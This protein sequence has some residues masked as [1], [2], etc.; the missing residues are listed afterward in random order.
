MPDFF[1][2]KDFKDDWDEFVINAKLAEHYN[3]AAQISGALL[4]HRNPILDALLP[5]LLYINLMSLL[6]GALDL[7][8]GIK[9]LSIPKTYRN[10]LNGKIGFLMDQNVVKNGTAL[11]TL[12]RKR[13]EAAHEVEHVD[14]NFF[15]DAI[16]V[17]NEELK[18][19]GFVD[20]KPEFQPFAERGAVKS[21]EDPGILGTREFRCGLKYP[22]GRLAAEFKWSE[23]LHRSRG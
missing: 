7:Y 23:K 11:H 18:H 10:D 20:D 2:D 12:R 17:V 6:D 13:N 21:S 9:K 14:W 22:G 8:M 1:L 16:D 4:A 5:S 15:H 3:M 19:L